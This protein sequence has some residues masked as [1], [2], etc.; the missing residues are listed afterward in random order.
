LQHTLE[1]FLAALVNTPLNDTLLNDISRAAILT[2]TSETRVLG[3]LALDPVSFS[4]IFEMAKSEFKEGIGGLY[5]RLSEDRVEEYEAL[6]RFIGFAYF[7]ALLLELVEV[8]AVT[9]KDAGTPPILYEVFGDPGVRQFFLDLY[10]PPRTR[11]SK[12]PSKAQE[13][14]RLST[15][16]WDTL[17]VQ[18][19]RIHR[20]GTTSFILRGRTEFVRG[21]EIALKCLIFPYTRVGIIESATR[22]YAIDYPSGEVPGT[23]KVFCSTAKWIMMEFVD[24]ITLRELL[25]A[26]SEK[27]SAN[28]HY[29]DAYQ[30]VEA[31]A[32][33]LIAA[34]RALTHKGYSHKDLAPSNIML[35]HRG[36]L[37]YDIVLIDLGRNYLYTKRIG[38]GETGEA[39]FVAPEIRDDGRTSTTSDLY[40]I[41]LILAE[42]CD[43]GRVQDGS[44]PEAVYMYRPALAR[45]IEDLIDVKPAQRMLLLNHISTDQYEAVTSSLG[46][47]LATSPI[48]YG[49]RHGI[50]RSTVDVLL[51]SSRQASKLF[52]FWLKSRFTKS[53]ISE[54]S[55]W[56]VAWSG[57]C[58]FNWLIVF[59]VCFLWGLR[60]FGIDDF[61]LPISVF[62]KMAGTG[63]SIPILDSLRAADYLTTDWRN[64]LPARVVG[65]TTGMACVKYYQ[66]IFSGLTIRSIR[67]RSAVGLEIVMRY[68][69]F[70]TFLPVLIGNLIEPRWTLWLLISGYFIIALNNYLAYRF[71]KRVF[72]DARLRFS[73]VNLA[74]ESTLRMFGQW[75][76]GMG[77]Y[78]IF[79]CGIATGL[80]VGILR[81]SYVYFTMVTLVSLFVFYLSKDILLGPV[82]RGVL[83]HAFISGERLAVPA[84]SAEGTE[85]RA[86]API[87]Q[88]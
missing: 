21:E 12:Q 4:A 85:L 80:Q 48:L 59:S 23:A 72:R 10:R 42:I 76:P 13:N 88:G 25:D 28:G 9:E 62:N 7:T 16:F 53:R 41:G 36:D 71:S 64:N 37:R 2:R 57:V 24:G 20:L 45:L 87:K 78:I 1:K 31:I 11:N 61:G 50:A 17:D 52:Q 67:G 65:M 18:S 83:T 66:N 60:D 29:P 30:L 75:W 84:A 27:I 43:P 14:A 46:D 15:I 74:A 58:T 70:C 77:L 68:C 5:E 40:S 55:G 54:N 73:T 82:V 86:R 38:I 39:F 51:P 69:A 26:R 47:I 32:F 81:D 3:H 44:V 79:L 56:L 6:R 19:L 22:D 33:P 34:L 8:K 49:N 35:I 63:N